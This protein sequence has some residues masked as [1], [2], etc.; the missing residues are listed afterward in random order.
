VS[1]DDLLLVI[2]PD[3]TAET[4]YDDRLLP[5]LTG[6][7]RLAVRRAS[8]VEPVTEGRF[9]VGWQA[10]LSPVGGPVLGP[11]ASRREALE[12]ETKWLRRSLWNDTKTTGKC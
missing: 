9:T 2:H 3:G 12:A 7:G 5:V 1:S 11:F 8:H 4:I 6:L 10:D